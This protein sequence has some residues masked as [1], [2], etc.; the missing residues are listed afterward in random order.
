MKLTSLCHRLKSDVTVFLLFVTSSIA[1]NVDLLTST[2]YRGPHDSMFGFSVAQYKS[3]RQSWLIVGAPKAQT[4]QP[5]VVQG[6]AVYRC[7]PGDHNRCTQLPFDQT[8]SETLDYGDRTLQTEDKS[9]QW[10]GAT[11]Q[12]SGEDGIIAACAPRY[13]YYGG[14]LVRR[15]PVGVCWTLDWRFS[16]PKKYSPC[17]NPTFFGP[18]RQGF[19][20]AGFSAAVTKDGSGLYIGA[21][22]SWYW[23][24][25]VFSQN[26][27]TGD[28]FETRESP[29]TYDDSY[30]GYSSAVGEFTGDSDMDVVVGVP[31]ANITG[32]VVL[33]NSKLQNLL[34]ISGDQIGSY[35]GY[36]L[37]VSDLNG[38]KLD[39]IVVGAPLHSD[40]KAKGEKYEEGRVYVYYQDTNH[41]FNVVV[42]LDGTNPKGR[43]GLALASLG[44]INRDGY[45]DIAV[46]APYGGKDGHGAVYI[47]HGSPE[48]IINKTSQII[49]PSDF[50]HGGIRTFGFSISGGMDL[51]NN[52]YP[53]LLVGAYESSRA[54]YFRS[55]PVVTLKGSLKVNVENI[56]LKEKNCVILDKTQVSCFFATLCLNYTGHDIDSELGFTYEVKLDSQKDPPQRAFF[57]NDPFKNEMTTT[58]YLS[59]GSNYCT[60]IYVYIENDIKDKLTSIALSLKFHLI[61]S[62][63]LEH[64]LNPILDQN[65]LVEL[66]KEVPIQKNCGEDDVCIPDLQLDVIPNMKKYF[67]G[68]TERIDLDV[69]ISNAGE[70]AFQAYMYLNMPLDIHYININKSKL[71]DYPVTCTGAKPETGINNLVCDIGNP[72]PAN[73]TLNFKVLLRAKKMINYIE[74]F[75]FNFTVNSTNAELPDR[76]FDNKQ[77]VYLPVE[78][79]AELSI[80]GASDPELVS[81]N[82]SDPIPEE[83]FS[84]EDVGPEVTHIYE[85]RNKGPS[86]IKTA[87]IYIL[88]PTYNLEKEFL[89]YL[90]SEPEIKG[91]EASCRINRDDI[92]QL[93]LEIQEKPKKQDL[94][95]ATE[96]GK[97]TPVP[98]KTKRQ[99]R[100]TLSLADELNCG[101][102]ICTKINCSVTNLIAGNTVS[103]TLRSR[104][105]RET[106]N[107]LNI[108]DVQISSKLVAMT[109]SLPLGVDPSKIPI[110]SYSVSTKI[111]LDDVG[112]KSAIPWWI[113]ILAVCG[114]LL[115][116]GL[117]ALLLWKLGF[118]KRKRPQEESEKQLLQKNG[119]QMARGDEAL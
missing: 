58:V 19:C 48:G 21:P 96:L 6:G 64:R 33:F 1:F 100:E 75:Q 51:D 37:C 59:E 43:F 4:N 70:N 14:N 34:N 79:E 61:D 93:S 30:L 39:D 45:Q 28:L 9:H 53:D 85:L 106:I 15:E 99:R 81:Y 52:N 40:F 13:V 66:V 7:I 105:W 113:L 119:Y 63:S 8:G 109:T 115:L 12:T 117:L 80:H 89:L 24:G 92:N 29:K 49:T 11:V 26:L 68:S 82:K 22:G 74:G 35:F 31:K 107:K 42:H 10:F 57:L 44:D 27:T 98:T 71:Q 54:I 86:T 73:K 5:G 87:N 36:S 60:E 94:L 88:W 56:D 101:P 78:V 32:K 20:Q 102:T 50:G 90:T 23:Q 18:H 72:L 38:D 104:L 62:I 69:T 95:N 17:R 91:K 47:Y 103:F 25:Q 41:Q 83:K 3:N 111:S 118:F 55:R 76:V 112:L 16:S 67:I 84:E 114:G 2:V 110:K 65:G 116:L 77:E 46:G 108:K 97:Q